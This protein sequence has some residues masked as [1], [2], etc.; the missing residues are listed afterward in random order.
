[1]KLSLWHK[2]HHINIE[3]TKD[4]IMEFLDTLDE[5]TV[6]PPSFTNPPV[7][8]WGGYTEPCIDGSIN[9]T[10]SDLINSNNVWFQNDNV[11]FN[12]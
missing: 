7:T 10:G 9:V 1:M 5:V 8:Y 2:G 12:T 6:K 3:G 4:E 11:E